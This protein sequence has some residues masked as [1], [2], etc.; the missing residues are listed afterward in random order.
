MP[1]D[2]VVRAVK[3]PFEQIAGWGRNAWSVLTKYSA[4]DFVPPTIVDTWTWIKQQV[5]RAF[6]MGTPGEQM[7]A[8]VVLAIA[9]IL[10]SLFSGGITL[11]FV[12]L[13]MLTFAGGALRL[14]PVIDD[15]W[16]WGQAET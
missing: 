5:P 8:S 13:F 9:A 1:G 14:W 10:T 12:G 7:S 11:V 15:L 16:P 2:I 6:G 4:A 3:W